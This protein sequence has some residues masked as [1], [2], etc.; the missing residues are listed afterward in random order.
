MLQ[1]NTERLLEDFASAYNAVIEAKQ[2]NIDKIAKFAHE[3]GYDEEKTKAFID[4]VLNLDN[5]DKQL[6]NNDK[7]SEEQTFVNIVGKY[8]YEVEEAPETDSQAIEEPY[9]LATNVATEDDSQI[10][11]YD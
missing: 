8:I 2:S 5:N 11:T 3:R 4:F 6:D 10:E 7:Q 1:V 9:G